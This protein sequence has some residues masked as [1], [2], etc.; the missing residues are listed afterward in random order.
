VTDTIFLTGFP[1]FLGSRLLPTILGR[2]PDERAV[3]LVQPRFGSLAKQ[4]VDDLEAA[5]P[6]LVGR[7]ELVAGD[8]TEP[9]L[10]L[11]DAAGLAGRTTEIW[12]LAAV[13]DLSVARDVGMRINVE[14]TRNLLRFAEGC[15]G[16]RRHHYVSTCYVSGRHCGI[17]RE[18]DLD[19][20]QR[21]NNFYE[22]TKFLAEVDVAAARD[23]GMPTTVYRP[24][25]VVGDSRTGDTQ[26]F[27]GPYF[28]LQWLLRQPRGLALV[29]YVGDPTMV[30]FTMVPSD[31]VIGA[32][33]HLSGLEASAGR[34]YQLADPRPLT[35]DELLDEMCRATD[36]RGVRV[37]LPHRLTTWTLD[38]V[39][40]VQRYVGIPASAVEYFVHP[41][42]Y[43]TTVATADLAGSGVACPPAAEYLPAL[44]RFMAEHREADVGVMI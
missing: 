29:P 40:P 12:H 3:C 14:G 37:R 18:G 31:F 30:R 43:D 5:D 36:R 41:T 13:Y 35:V 39:T 2:A 10:G 19:V 15:A 20:G 44:V 16:L 24:A 22:E 21:F 8:L 17:F 1:G 27:D 6:G 4:R 11:G 26:K 33:A 38:H 34:T 28:L 42:H 23:G 32:I 25:I 7:I 9:G